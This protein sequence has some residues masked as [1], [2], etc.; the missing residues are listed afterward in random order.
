MNATQ[1]EGKLVPTARDT[2]FRGRSISHYFVLATTS[3]YY[4][5]RTQRA[6]HGPQKQIQA[7]A[8]LTEVPAVVRPQK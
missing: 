3:L 6:L 7:I 2:Q 8:A 5:T 4:Y 1:I